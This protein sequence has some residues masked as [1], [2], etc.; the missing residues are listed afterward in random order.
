MYGNTSFG[1]LGTLQIGATEDD[2]T[3]GIFIGT[4]DPILADTWEIKTVNF[5]APNNATHI[6]VKNSEA[7]PWHQLD[8][9][10]IE[11]ACTPL[12]IDASDTELCFDEELVLTATGEGAVTWEDGI[13]NGEEFIPES[14]GIITY[15]ATSD[16]EDD[17]PTSIDI[18]VFELPE[19]IAT[20]DELVICLGDAILLAGDGTATEYIWDPEE[21]EDGES[22]IP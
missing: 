13:I 10:S 5:I 17:C 20:V 15:T 1:S 14:T 2:A 7:G 8:G 4:S 3:A 11:L 19:V 21:V 22:F 6:S 16:S 9:F 18:E 12:E